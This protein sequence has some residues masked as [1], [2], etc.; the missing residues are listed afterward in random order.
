M[1][2]RSQVLNSAPCFGE[3]RLTTVFPRMVGSRK[4]PPGTRVGGRGLRQLPTA[5]TVRTH[6]FQY[7]ALQHDSDA[8]SSPLPLHALC[9]ADRTT[10]IDSLLHAGQMLV[11]PFLFNF[12]GDQASDFVQAVGFSSGATKPR[13]GNAASKRGLAMELQV[14]SPVAT[15]T[16]FSPNW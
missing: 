9:S 4:A 5:W 16:A 2:D 11:W 7:K 14:V 1:F 6:R 12:L 3:T 10:L 15:F 13:T 8:L